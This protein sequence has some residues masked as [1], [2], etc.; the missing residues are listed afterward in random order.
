VAKSKS[1]NKDVT[2]PS[3]FEFDV[4]P[5]WLIQRDLAEESETFNEEISYLGISSEIRSLLSRNLALP[6]K[7][8]KALNVAS[9]ALSCLVASIDRPQELVERGLVPPSVK[10]ALPKSEIENRLA[11]MYS[12]ATD[13]TIAMRGTPLL[14]ARHVG[15][16]EEL[17]RHLRRGYWL[18]REA[19]EYA[20]DLIEGKV[21]RAANRPKRQEDDQR[22]REIVWFILEARDGDMGDGQ[23]IE[24]AVE[25][26]NLGR[27]RIQKIFREYKDAERAH[28]AD[29]RNLLKDL[30]A[31]RSDIKG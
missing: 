2:R 4:A 11:Q 15:D 25:E 28:F 27:R 1:Q 17:V 31:L 5:L 6:P 14:Y 12:R 19:R 13:L 16:W 29:T 7:Y 30:V 9:Q 8:R 26:F 18:S 3:R 20:A 21:R 10:S 22:N 23:S 24:A